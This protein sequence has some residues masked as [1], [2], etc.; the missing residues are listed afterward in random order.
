MFWWHGRMRMMHYMTRRRT[1]VPGTS[2]APWIRCNLASKLIGLP[3]AL[4]QECQ[5]HDE[6]HEYRSFPK[7]SLRTLIGKKL[8]C[9][10]GARVMRR[11]VYLEPHCWTPALLSRAAPS[12]MRSQWRQAADA[13]PAWRASLKRYIPFSFALHSL[14]KGR[15]V[16]R[17]R[18]GYACAYD[19]LPNTS[20]YVVRSGVQPEGQP[21]IGA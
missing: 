15:P 1:A 8:V 3:G 7:F 4:C 13:C 11:P 12:C 14:I 2:G 6:S 17:S 19:S 10:N 18:A 9:T 20:A 16:L 5:K 21:E